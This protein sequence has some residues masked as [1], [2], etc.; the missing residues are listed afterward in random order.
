MAMAFGKTAVQAGPAKLK[1]SDKVAELERK[2]GNVKSDTQIPD[3]KLGAD[4]CEA[5][6]HCAS[7]IGMDYD[8]SKDSTYQVIVKKDKDPMLTGPQLVAYGSGCAVKWGEQ[9]VPLDDVPVSSLLVVVTED[10]GATAFL[11]TAGH[12]MP[13]RVAIDWELV[14]DDRWKE[15]K[16]DFQGACGSTFSALSSFLQRG[17]PLLKG[18]EIPDGSILTLWALYPFFERDEKGEST[19]EI[20]SYRILASL[21]EEPI[22]IWSPGSADQWS[23]EGF[24]SFQ[25]KKDGSNYV[26][27]KDETVYQGGFAKV[28]ALE[29]GVEYHIVGFTSAPDKYNKGKMSYTMTL[30]DPNGKTIDNVSANKAISNRLQDTPE[31]SLS[32]DNFGRFVIDSVG[33]TSDNKKMAKIKYVIMPQDIDDPLAQ[34]FNSSQEAEDDQF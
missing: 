27:L 23:M 25:I 18:E 33:L 34:L 13:I 9:L 2:I 28:S 12:K 32:K 10:K 14:R 4:V 31:G 16:V 8:P 20:K 30:V 17:E 5:L 26:S 24:E 11:D 1:L 19:G 22:M 7:L 6:K 21:G 3:S 15:S 29:P